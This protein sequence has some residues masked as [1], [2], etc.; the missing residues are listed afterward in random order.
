M[1]RSHLR[2]F[3]IRN[4]QTVNWRIV[5]GRPTFTNADVTPPPTRVLTLENL[6]FW[7]DV[8]EERGGLPTSC[9]PKIETSIRYLEMLGQGDHFYPVRLYEDHVYSVDLFHGMGVYFFVEYRLDTEV[10]K[11]SVMYT[12]RAE[13]MRTFSNDKAFGKLGIQ[14]DEEVSFKQ[15]E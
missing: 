14:W 15:E 8:K 11:K 13:A 6:E 10:I 9:P 5:G 12:D 3:R 4:P 2:A 1:K 7:Q